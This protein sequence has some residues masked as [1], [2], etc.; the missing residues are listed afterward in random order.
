MQFQKIGVNVLKGDS[1][2]NRGQ[3]RGYMLEIVIRCFLEQNGWKPLDDTEDGR[4]RMS[5]NYDVEVRGRGTWHQIDVLCVYQSKIPFIY[6]LRLFAEVKF[7]ANELYKDKIRSYIG[8]MK[9]ITENYFAY[10]KKPQIRYTDIGVI[11][12]ANG[13]HDEASNLAFAHGIKVVSYKDNPIMK[14]IKTSIEKLEEQIPFRISIGNGHRVTFMTFLEMTLANPTDDNV[15][16]FI[17]TYQFN[18]SVKENLL[19][20]I[21]SIYTVKTNFFGISAN[22]ILLH[23]F[24]QGTF[25]E[26]LFQDTDEQWCEVHYSRHNDHI[27]TWI[28]FSQDKWHREFYFDV[29]RGLEQAIVDS[30]DILRAKEGL[31]EGLS[32]M[33]I[34]RGVARLLTIHVDKAERLYERR[35]GNHRKDNEF[36]K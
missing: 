16:E 5:G 24:S 17:A 21:Q 22:G 29:P 36:D 11:F 27:D 32:I 18:Y 14:S 8:I 4:I 34:L 9:D 6:P 28:T 7:T 35:K 20:L 33:Y 2:V 26:E 1:Y 10:A 19:N 31:F 30:C 13:F 23:F 12:S 25:P 15:N 3:L